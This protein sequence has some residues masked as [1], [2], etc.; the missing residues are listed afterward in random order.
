MILELAGKAK[1]AA[2]LALLVAGALTFISLPADGASYRD[3]DL[4]AHE[5][6]WATWVRYSSGH[7]EIMLSDGVQARQVTNDGGGK[8][9]PRVNGNGSV[10]WHSSYG[11]FI[12]HDGEIKR[13][14]TPRK[15][16]YSS[17]KP[18]NDKGQAVWTGV[19]G[20]WT[21]VFFYDG[22]ETKQLTHDD[23]SHWAPLIANDGSVVWGSNVG[24]N[25]VKIMRFDGTQTTQINE[26]GL[27]NRY[28]ISDNGLVAW[29][30]FEPQSQSHH[31]IYVFDGSRTRRI[32]DT[33]DGFINI[34]TDI[35]SKGWITFIRG[36]DY[37]VDPD[38][39]L[40]LQDQGMFLYDGKEMVLIDDLGFTPTSEAQ[41]NEMGMVT[42]AASKRRSDETGFSWLEPAEIFLYD[43]VRTIQV[44]D[45]DYEDLNPHLSLNG[46]YTIGG[47]A[48]SR[49]GFGATALSNA[50]GTIDRVKP[51]VNLE[52]P[53]VS[54]KISKTRTFK[55]K[56]S[57]G[58][59]EV[60]W[61]K[62][63]DRDS[64]IARAGATGIQS[65]TVQVRP[66]NSRF[67]TD[68]KIDTTSAHARFSGRPGRTYYFRVLAK[69][70]AGNVGRSSM[71][72]VTVPL[73]EGGYYR[74]SGFGGYIKDEK[75]RDYRS[76]V[77]YS[78][79][80]GD[81]IVYKLPEVKGVGLI[82][83]KGP[84]RGKAKIFMDGKYIK[85]VD[86]YSERVR[87][88]RQIFYRSFEKQGTHFLKV[89]NEGTPG[90]SRFDIDAVAAVR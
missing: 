78:R 73:N 34:P 12:Y 23:Y 27:I 19:A 49:N 6:G 64:R 18:I 32:T 1:Y 90:R 9:T 81:E 42:W 7:Y 17:Y 41:L 76:S 15:N 87:P 82:V 71:K 5:K 59:P 61:Q 68:L 2:A 39:Q 20:Q 70:R 45:D 72:M 16:S 69:D 33:D 11:V 48:L 8:N 56:W 47:S 79:Q 31:E 51:V 14:D 25:R 40:L 36:F 85:T 66:A 10:L 24:P 67:W 74:R 57:A 58:D 4:H 89:V 75:S 88:R 65:Y 38:K 35:N 44:T 46:L 53:F 54:T 26:T 22:K 63:A 29:N 86:A 21:Q 52:A 30:Q 80:A 50:S 55:V 83:N 3:F 37:P 84:D 60:V 43:G 77:R 28:V 13:I 62:G